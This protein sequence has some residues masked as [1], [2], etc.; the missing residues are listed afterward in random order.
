MARHPSSLQGPGNHL[1]WLNIALLL[2]YGIAGT[3]ALFQRS[4][5]VDFAI[6]V[7]TIAGFLFGTVLVANHVIELFVAGRSFAVV[8]SSVLLTLV[9]FGGGWFGHNG[10]HRITPAGDS[11]WCVVRN[12]GNSGAPLCRVPL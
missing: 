4:S 3:W 10:T 5:G 8:I 1:L 9:L 7:G 12:R 2:T 6:H 11:R